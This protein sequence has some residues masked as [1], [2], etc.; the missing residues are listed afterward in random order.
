MCL[1]QSGAESRFVPLQQ[2]HVP[3]TDAVFG[4]V[5]GPS[6]LQKWQPRVLRLVVYVITRRKGSVP[7]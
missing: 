6:P 2:L 1:V 5:G 3:M 7:E 4:E